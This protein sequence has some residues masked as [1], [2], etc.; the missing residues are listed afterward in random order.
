MCITQ[1]WLTQEHAHNQSAQSCSAA[2]QKPQQLQ[3]CDRPGE[4][5]CAT[6]PDGYVTDPLRRLTVC[7]GT[8]RR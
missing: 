5:H 2:S 7:L 1:R 6:E 3:C 4:T 8:D